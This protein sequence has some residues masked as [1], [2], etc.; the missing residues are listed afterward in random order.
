MISDLADRGRDLSLKSRKFNKL[1]PSNFYKGPSNEASRLHQATVGVSSKVDYLRLVKFDLIV[2]SI[3]K[4]ILQG[5][6]Q[7]LELH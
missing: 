1:E 2:R 6:K 3:L 7:K 4:R 5:M